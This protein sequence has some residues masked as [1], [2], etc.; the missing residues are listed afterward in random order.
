[1]HVYTS[2]YIVDPFWH[3]SSGFPD[4]WGRKGFRILDSARMILA[5]SVVIFKTVVYR[6][7]GE[8][9]AA[10]A[11]PCAYMALLRE[12]KTIVILSR[13]KRLRLKLQAL[14]F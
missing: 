11:E 9:Q 2:A 5:S 4:S 13:P 14:P 10:C 7:R 1:M 6:V 8:G 12:S 3:L